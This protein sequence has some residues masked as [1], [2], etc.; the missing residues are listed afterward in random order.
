MAELSCL[1]VVLDV[2]IAG[3][4]VTANEVQ[5]CSRVQSTCAIRGNSTRC[6]DR[7]ANISILCAK[8]PQCLATV[9]LSCVNMEA[10]PDPPGFQISKLRK[11]QLS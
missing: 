1:P 3:I 7:H 9:G 2:S 5:T 11:W 8:L 10:T 6:I 4:D